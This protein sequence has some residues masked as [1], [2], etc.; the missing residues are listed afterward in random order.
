MTKPI[1]YKKQNKETFILASLLKTYQEKCEAE[2][3]R[4]ILDSERRS[5]DTEIR[6]KSQKIGQCN[7]NY[8]RILKQYKKSKL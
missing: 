2:E 5:I 3:K 4:R 6:S 1:P 7:S 8:D